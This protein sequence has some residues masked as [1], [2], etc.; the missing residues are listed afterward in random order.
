MGC[1]YPLGQPRDAAVN[2]SLPNPACG[3]RS[4]FEGGHIFFSNLIG[5][6]ALIYVS[7]HT[8][9][10]GGAV[11]SVTNDDT[12]FVNLRHF[13]QFGQPASPKTPANSL[14]MRHLSS[15]VCE[16]LWP[17]TPPEPLL[18]DGGRT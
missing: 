8:L 11:K 6:R 4:L 1:S 14:K 5:S 17:R 16:L 15:L 2:G 3:H 13:R 18:M 9:M 7:S 10:G 12:P